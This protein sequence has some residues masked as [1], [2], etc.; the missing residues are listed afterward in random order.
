V[1][2]IV[3]DAAGDEVYF[4]TINSHR[5]LSSSSFSSLLESGQESGI[6]PFDFS[7]YMDQVSDDSL[8]SKHCL[9]IFSK[10]PLTMQSNSALELVHQFFV[11]LGAR[12]VVVTDTDGFCKC[13]ATNYTTQRN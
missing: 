7:I 8:G 11:K 10:A 4:H 1:I 13:S 5:G 3:A 9:L 12:Y 2:G 6:D